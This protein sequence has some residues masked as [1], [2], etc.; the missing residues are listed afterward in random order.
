MCR[1][2]HELER[3]VGLV[4]VRRLRRLRPGITWMRGYH[5]LAHWLIQPGYHLTISSPW[6]SPGPLRLRLARAARGRHA[7]AGAWA[8]DA[9][10][11]WLMMVGF[12]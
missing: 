4:P 1:H 6:L 9:W 10:N 5:Y 8:A 11:K 3:G 7:G 12:C 2:S